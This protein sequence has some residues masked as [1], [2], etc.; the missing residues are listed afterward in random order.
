MA[1][2]IMSFSIFPYLIFLY[3]VWRIW[4]LDPSLINKTTFLGFS[5]MLGFV[6]VTA[7]AGITAVKIMGASTL[8][9]VD[10]LHGLAESGLTITNGLIAYGLKKQLDTYKPQ[11][12]D[13][14]L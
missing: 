10:W 8:G 13:D 11:P 3:L 7:C 5:A 14:D 12:V 2:T 4:K 1:D 9:H 6:F